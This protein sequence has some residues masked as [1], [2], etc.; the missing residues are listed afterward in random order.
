[1][2]CHSPDPPSY[3]SSFSPE[4]KLYQAFIFSVPIFFAFVI[5]FLFYVFFMRRRASWQSLRMRTTNLTRGEHLRPSE[6][7]VTKELREM[8]PVVVF[9]ESFSVRETQCSVCLGD[10]QAEDRLQRLPQCGHTFHVDCIDHWLVSNTTCP[11]CRISLIPAIKAAADSVNQ[12]YQENQADG[13]QR[14]SFAVHDNVDLESERN[15]DDELRADDIP[16]E[17]E[18]SRHDEGRSVVIGVDDH[19]G[20]EEN[21]R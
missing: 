15:F 6:L 5:L 8:L 3:C 2:S 19:D 10:Y 16:R 1:M 12:E 9:K 13:S 21:H 20:F 14:Q 11:L 18:F 17:L 7:G 4:L